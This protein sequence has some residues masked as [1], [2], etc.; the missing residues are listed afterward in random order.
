M[1]TEVGC[2]QPPAVRRQHAPLMETWSASNIIPRLAGRSIKP[3]RRARS[4][5]SLRALT[6]TVR[7][8]RS[9]TTPKPSS[10]S[11]SPLV[12]PAYLLETA[13]VNHATTS[14]VDPAAMSSSTYLANMTKPSSWSTRPRLGSESHILAPTV[15]MRWPLNS[16]AHARPASGSP[17]TYELSSPTSRSPLGPVSSKP[18]GCHTYVG[19]A[20]VDGEVDEPVYRADGEDEADGRHARTDGEGLGVVA[21]LDH[22]GAVG[23]ALEL[24]LPHELEDGRALG[25]G[26]ERYQGVGVGIPEVLH[27]HAHRLEP[28]VALGGLHC[29]AVA[30]RLRDVDDAVLGEE[31]HGAVGLHREEDVVLAAREARKELVAAVALLVG[32]EAVGDGL[33]SRGVVRLEQEVLAAV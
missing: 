3:R 1:D 33:G 25:D 27:L 18:G 32:V 31:R 23:F 26:G 19:A 14:G 30:A 11:H 9:C 16:A 28:L 21:P 20:D 10:V 6:L 4:W 7:L 24:V 5:M 8:A 2:T 15:L 29:L 22:A 12:Q 17:Y 13:S